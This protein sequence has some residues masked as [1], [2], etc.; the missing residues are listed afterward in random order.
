[1]PSEDRAKVLANIANNGDRA[2]VQQTFAESEPAIDA[3]SVYADAMFANRERLNKLGAPVQARLV[4]W[5]PALSRQDDPLLALAV[6]K[7]Y[8]LPFA[9]DLALNRLADRNTPLRARELAAEI[10]LDAGVERYGPNVLNVVSQEQES[11]STRRNLARIYGGYADTETRFA[12]LL[13]ALEQAPMDVVAG[14]VESLSMQRPGVDYLLR[15]VEAKRL[16][17]SHINNH[18]T[19][20]RIESVHR[21]DALTERYLALVEGVED[22]TAAVR[23]QIAQFRGALMNGDEYDLANGQRVFEESCVRCHR[24]AGQGSMRGPSLDGLAARGIDRILQDVLLPN[25]DI[26]PAFQTTMIWMLDGDVVDGQVVAEDASTLTVVNA[27]DEETRVN[28]DDI[29]ERRELWISPMPSDFGTVL[30]DSDFVDL[31]YF[32]MNPPSNLKLE[33]AIAQGD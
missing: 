20:I 19:R 3:L 27:Q 7:H 29:D 31:M 25:W 22:N 13:S 21:D 14:A 33:S 17:P 5:W 1:V 10:L 4:D 23:T 8:A 11:A 12:A 16:S 30:P 2:A 9:R 26:D 6:G 15:E 32:L 28:K 18:V 24:I